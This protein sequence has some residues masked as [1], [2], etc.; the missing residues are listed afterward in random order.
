MCFDVAR[1]VIWIFELPLDQQIRAV[2]GI[3]IGIFLGFERGLIVVTI[4][5]DRSGHVVGM[6]MHTSPQL[7]ARFKKAYRDPG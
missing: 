3:G 1:I 2:R 5:G 4:T 7:A 6:K